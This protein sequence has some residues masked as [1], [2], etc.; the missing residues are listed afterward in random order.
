[1]IVR[2]LKVGD[3]LAQNRILACVEELIERC[4]GR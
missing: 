2:G 3:G 1:M 4:Y